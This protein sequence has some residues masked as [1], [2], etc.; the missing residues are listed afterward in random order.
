M[1]TLLPILLSV[2]TLTLLLNVLLPATLC[3]AHSA[4]LRTLVF[5]LSAGHCFVA[6]S[7]LVFQSFWATNAAMQLQG[8]TLGPIG[9]LIHYDGLAGLMLLLVSFVGM[10]VCRYS[11]RY[12]DGDATQGNYFRWVAATIGSVSLLVISGNLLLF[13]LAWVATSLSLHQL[14]L[15]YGDRSGAKRAAW[16]KFRIS[17]V[18]DAFLLAAMALVFI[19]FGTFDFAELFAAVGQGTSGAA[20][21]QGMISAIAWFFILGA[22]TKSAQFPLH[23]WLPETL[24]TPTPVSALMHAGVVNAGGYLVIRLSPLLVEAPTAL[25]ALAIV[26]GITAAVAGIVMLTQTSV[27][28]TLAYSTIAQMGFMMLQCGL[29]AFSA[30]MLHI[31]AHSLYKAYAFLNSGSVLQEAKRTKV[32]PAAGS[33]RPAVLALILPTVLAIYFALAFSLGLTE[34]TG[35]YALGVILSMAVALGLWESMATLAGRSTA[36]LLAAASGVVA[37]YLGGYLIVSQVVGECVAKLPAGL[38]VSVSTGIVIALFAG[39][40]LLQVLLA[41]KRQHGWLAALQV[42]AANGFYVDAATRRLF[43]HL[44]TRS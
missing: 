13:F 39:L 44:A 41:S 9:S 12:L 28:K 43:G 23:S 38:A 15:H 29:G 11:I 17:R 32:S 1:D 40:V 2:S 42:H 6:A 20:D 19:E 8:F 33:A 10:V 22:V 30:A 24:E 27:K 35:G 31:V 21:N 3:N 26:G 25:A 5:G 37:L 16:T 34:K 14:L 4:R 36:G 7:A 18:G